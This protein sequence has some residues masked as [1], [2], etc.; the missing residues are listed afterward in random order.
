MTSATISVV[1]DT[2]PGLDD[3]LALFVACASPE[4]D[5]LGVTTVGGNV[6]IARTTAN[7]LTV[8]DFAG[9]PDIPV[10]AG[11]AEP[12]ERPAIEAG[13][14]HS[15]DG[16]GGLAFP[17]SRRQADPRDAVSWLS[18]LLSANH[19]K[20]ISILALG[21]LTNIAKLIR[22]DAAAASRI[23]RVVAMGGAV[24]SPGNVTPAAEF[25]IA[26][27]PEAADIVFRSGIPVTLA[28]LD[29]TRQ[30][31]ADTEWA[32]RLA[33]TGPVGEMSHQ[34]HRAYLRNVTTYRAS[35]G[36][37][38]PPPTAF[39][40]H[41]P[42]VILQMIDPSLFTAEDLPLR[43]VCDGGEQ[44]GATVIDPGHGSTVSVLTKAD[45]ARALALTAARISSL[46]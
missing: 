15:E 39:P 22:A 44:D 21:P 43:V 12:I 5:I 40:L 33:T 6:G 28:P 46:R 27:D 16:L 36:S 19:V 37:I 10:F 29:V 1:I 11:A 35:K 4:L 32:E 41:D 42:C 13:N 45:A 2:D 8:L 23:E 14:I 25:N 38:E 34:L 24:R 31:G 18:S 9:R 17:K 20:S 3:A 30:V 7:A 26:A